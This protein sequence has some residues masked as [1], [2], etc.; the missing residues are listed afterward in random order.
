MK[1]IILSGFLWLLESVSLTQQLSRLWRVISSLSLAEYVCVCV[2]GQ[3]RG[4][5]KRNKKLLH[6]K[7]LIT[8]CAQSWLLLATCRL[9][10]TPFTSRL[11]F[12]ILSLYVP[13]YTCKTVF[14]CRISN[15]HIHG[16]SHVACYLQ[17]SVFFSSLLLFLVGKFTKFFFFSNYYYLQ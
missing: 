2:C 15:T 11:L 7:S 14:L 9:A 13:A 16:L 3:T 8:L 6:T 4:K 17:F 12:L 1:L 10:L 5:G